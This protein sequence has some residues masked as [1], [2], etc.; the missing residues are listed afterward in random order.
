MP[1]DRSNPKRRRLE[2]N[3]SG[4][5]V[6]IVSASDYGE[7]WSSYLY[8]PSIEGATPPLANS[9]SSLLHIPYASFPPLE[10]Q[11]QPQLT[12][13]SFWDTRAT[14]SSTQDLWRRPTAIGAPATTHFS[15]SSASYPSS[16][17]LLDAQLYR[18]LTSS[19]QPSTC[20]P[21]TL[22]TLSPN[23]FFQAQLTA[24]PPVTRCLP[25]SEG[26]QTSPLS[27]LPSSHFQSACEASATGYYPSSESFHD[28][29][30]R[31]P[32]EVVCFGEVS[33]SVALVT[34]APLDSKN[35]MSRRVRAF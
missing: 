10:S 16:S 33:L 32:R 35:A 26:L 20:I 21:D 22:A 31:D 19:T 14:L 1:P 9:S 23:P 29:L 28:V 11:F 34:Y 12:N 5:G 8:Q 30:F 15:V 6:N 27:W 13:S 7:E 4:Q 3:P 18:P 17:T 24:V 25:D 2:T